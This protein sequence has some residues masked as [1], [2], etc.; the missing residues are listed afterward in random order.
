MAAMP[1]HVCEAIAIHK[2][3]GMTVDNGE[4]WEH[5]VVLLPAPNSQAGRAPGLAQVASF[6]GQQSWSVLLSCQQWTILSQLN[7]S[8]R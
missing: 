1:L 3:Q 5:L 7:C 4:T 2:S 6:Q 8:G